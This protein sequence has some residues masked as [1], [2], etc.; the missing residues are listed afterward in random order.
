M[1]PIIRDFQAGD[2]EA[3]ARLWEA[4]D[5]RVDSREDVLFKLRRD[6]DLFLVAEDR[7]RIVGAVLG[8]FD[9][10]MGSIN[11][12]AVADSWR[13]SG[14]ASRLIREVEDRLRA[15]GARR[16]W[17]WIHD[18]NHASRTLFARRGYEEWPSVVT[19]SKSLTEQPL[20]EAPEVSGGDLTAEAREE[21]SA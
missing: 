15:R 17:A 14:L 9:G 1:A 20:A 21:P 18:H 10:R 6:A 19:A 7:G 12:L 11:R 3:V 4:S 13:R 16:V 8:A 5:I 2:Y